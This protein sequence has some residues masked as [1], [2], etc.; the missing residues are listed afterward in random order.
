[1]KV[2][3][4]DVGGTHVK[5]LATGE[6]EPV[7]IKSGPKMSA[8]EMVK[9]VRA[10]AKNWKYDCVTIGYP[11]VVVHDKP[12]HEPHN[13]APGWVGFDYAKAFGKPVRM[14]NDAAMQAMGAYHG[15]RMLFLG[16][17]T[18]L[19]SA[20]IVD[21]VIEPME[22]AHLPYR[23]SRTYED[24]VGEAGLQRLGKKRWRKHVHA[25]IDLLRAAVEADYVILGGGN[26]R[27]LQEMPDGVQLGGNDDAFAGG[28]RVWETPGKPTTHR[29]KKPA[30]K[31][32]A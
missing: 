11:G 31:E 30:S 4:V 21:G 15:S 18:G 17:G 26:A 32:T 20:L 1:M 27:L 29:R 25:V 9:S 13:L 14:L 3:V 2:L 5:V 10:A 28:F 23:R 19:G 22:L 7:K 8:K 6:A 24:Y 16:L 12:V